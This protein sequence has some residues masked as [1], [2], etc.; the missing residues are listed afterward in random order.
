MKPGASGCRNALPSW[1]TRYSR[2]N[3]IAMPYTADEIQQRLRLGE[4][5]AWEFKQIEFRG[6]RPFA[7]RRDDLADEIGAFANGGGGVLLCGVT[8]AGAVQGGMSRA[9]LDNL[10]RL[11]VEIGR[12]SVKPG[13]NIGVFRIAMPDDG[14]VLLAEIPQGYAAHESPGGVF[15]RVGSSKRPL[16]GDE[17][18]R[19][20][21]RRGQARFV[22][23]DEQPV[24]HTGFG[25]LDESLWR[26]LLS[27]TSAADPEV[28]LT[29]MGLLAL[30][31]YNVTRATVAGLLIASK[32]PELWLGNAYITATR[33]YGNDRASG[34][35]DSQDI[36][37]PAPD[38]IKQAL[39]FIIRNM[40]VATI[41][42]PARR[43]LPQY[44]ENALF[45]AIVNAVVHRDYSIRA[46]RIR[47][48]MFD[49]RVEIN[50]PGGLP[51]NLTVDSIGERQVTR[52]EALTSILARVPVVGIAGAGEREYLMERRGDGITI[53]RRETQ[54]LCGRPPEFELI[55]DAE[56]RVT[57]PAANLDQTG[58]VAAVAVRS[59]QNPVADAA[60]LALF[61]NQTGQSATTDVNG[62]ALLEVYDAQLP[63]TVFI[64]AIGHRAQLKPDWVP[65]E[66]QLFVALEPQPDSGAVIFS[67]GTGCIPGLSGRLNPIRDS[68]DRT[69]L[70]ASNIA[71]N[72]GQ[73]QPVHFVPGDEMALTD[74]NG[75]QA[76]IR[77]LDI[78]GRAALVEYRSI[79]HC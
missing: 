18:L 30:D 19:L 32:T 39:A 60:V 5:S 48:A 31:E 2:R 34:Q 77:I 44:S 73:Q 36:Y 65:A 50:S 24:P 66:G 10:E 42:T 72:G 52:N 38:Q 6:D 8:D 68:L 76:A 21:Q 25:S 45:E 17:Y 61:P 33:Y 70:Y 22:W 14:A 55:N 78:V 67:D 62:N 29:R 79:P 41:K 63:M 58:G 1:S 51:N 69:Y 49:D 35:T 23:Y 53:I 7:P 13:V 57:I 12:D 20:A 74:A 40:K 28:A 59:G 64:A 75:Q 37:G 9:Q 16:I 15:Q 47:I 71:I 3:R 43:N 54:A 4:D 26:P 46:S 11:L 27:V 56:L